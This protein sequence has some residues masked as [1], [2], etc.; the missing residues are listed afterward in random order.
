[1]DIGKLPY[2]IR[3]LLYIK[4]FLQLFLHPCKGIL[5]LKLHFLS[6]ST[7]CR[8]LLAPDFYYKHCHLLTRITILGCNDIPVN[9][10]ITDCIINGIIIRLQLIEHPVEVMAEHSYYGVLDLRSVCNGCIFPLVHKY[11]QEAYGIFIVRSFHPS[12][13]KSLLFQPF[14]FLYLGFVTLLA[15]SQLFFTPCQKAAYIRTDKW[16]ISLKEIGFVFSIFSDHYAIHI[17]RVTLILPLSFQF[18]CHG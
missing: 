14:F 5:L 2:Y 11:I 4:I 8:S 17:G 1:M 13:A 7:G 10:G 9:I 12:L 18:F 16:K 15:A 3:I 6:F